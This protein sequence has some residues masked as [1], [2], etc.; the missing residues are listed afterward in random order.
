LHLL[1]SGELRKDIPDRFL[2]I[3]YLGHAFLEAKHWREL[4]LA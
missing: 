3:C 2:E 4:D 1:L